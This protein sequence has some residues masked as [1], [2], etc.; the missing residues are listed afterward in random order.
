MDMG[1]QD[2]YIG[3]LHLALFSVASLYARQLHSND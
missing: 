3:D 2:A 1:G